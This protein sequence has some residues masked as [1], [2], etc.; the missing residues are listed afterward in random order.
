[1]EEKTINGGENQTLKAALGVW[2]GLPPENGVTT[3]HKEASEALLLASW[4]RM[5]E[6]VPP[7]GENVRRVID[8]AWR[9]MEARMVK[10]SYWTRMIDSFRS[11][12]ELIRPMLL[13]PALVAMAV[14]GIVMYV[15]RHQSV[16]LVVDGK[17]IDISREP[18]MAYGSKPVTGTL[19]G[20]NLTMRGITKL[21]AFTDSKQLRLG[22]T[23]GK[24]LVDYPQAAKGKKFNIS[25]PRAT[26]DVTGTKFLI[27]STGRN[28]SLHVIEGEV[29]ATAKGERG[30]VKAGS[31]WSSV[32]PK[33][34][35]SD[36]K[37]V[38]KAMA[39][40]ESTTTAK[41]PVV[42][43]KAKEIMASVYLNSG[44]II[45]GRLIADGADTV[46]LELSSPKRKVSVARDDVS[47]V[48]R[49]N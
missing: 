20:I 44:Q 28:D 22:F 24:I 31:N 33:N 15:N 47:K 14:A 40:F 37:L 30:S 35:V 34:V 12:R 18:F 6:P 11:V 5:S 48:V 3:V 10:V 23:S 19:D 2:L 21:R 8:S 45:K 46:V 32:A 27:D 13:G 16:Y 49:E 39:E 4:S 38:E 43:P 41:P 1:M 7:I 42:K 17:K 25:D 36:P 26:Y 9:K 29:K